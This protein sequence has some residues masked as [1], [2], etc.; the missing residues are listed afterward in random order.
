MKQIHYLIVS[1]LLLNGIAISSSYSQESIKIGIKGGLNVANIRGYGTSPDNSP[2]PGFHAGFYANIVLKKKFGIAVEVLYS[3][4]GTITKTNPE[5]FVRINYFEIPV[6]F[7]YELYERLTAQVGLTI[8][9]PVQAYVRQDSS[10]SF[11]NTCTQPTL[12]I[13]IGMV[14][15][16]DNGLN[17]G[18]RADFGA[19]NISTPSGDG[20]KNYVFML[21]VGYSF[22]KKEK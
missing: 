9:F 15:E 7:T 21:S 10:R 11:L 18:W 8:G 12:S 16:F 6:L 20:G 2:Q 4:K 19:S 5:Y 22:Y 14:Y 3:Q 1:F 13:P 17:L